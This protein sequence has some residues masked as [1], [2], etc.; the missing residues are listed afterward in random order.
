MFENA[1]PGGPF[2]GIESSDDIRGNRRWVFG[3]FRGNPSSPVFRDFQEATYFQCPG[4]RRR[5]EIDELEA[6]QEIGA[7]SLST[8]RVETIGPLSSPPFVSR[9][10][11]KPFLNADG[12]VSIEIM[13]VLERRRLRRTGLE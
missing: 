3:R 9:S 7:T 5:I 6:W 8:G 4:E 10:S 1:R 12:M 11:E 13:V 2:P